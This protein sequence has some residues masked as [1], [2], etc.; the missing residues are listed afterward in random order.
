MCAEKKE[1]S[2]EILFSNMIYSPCHIQWKKKVGQ[3]DEIYL[4]HT[5]D[6]SKQPAVEHWEY[7]KAIGYVLMSYL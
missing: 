2:L 1:E 3:H 5:L 6:G 7:L 4:N